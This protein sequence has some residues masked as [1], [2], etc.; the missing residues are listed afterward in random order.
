MSE[1]SPFD[2][3]VWIRRSRSYFLHAFCL[4]ALARYLLV[5]NSYCVDLWMCMVAYELK[6]DNLVGLILVETLNGLDAFHSKEV[7]FHH[8]YFS[9]T[10]ALFSFFVF[11]LFL[12]TL[13][14][15]PFFFKYGYKRGFG[16]F[17]LPL[18]LSAPTSLGI[19]GTA[20]FIRMT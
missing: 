5:Q 2:V 15:L 1:N 9:F 12:Y 7:S 20:G 10:H 3:S 16:C 8:H 14:F 6:R 18:Y 4:C 13:P 17:N 11:F 19:V